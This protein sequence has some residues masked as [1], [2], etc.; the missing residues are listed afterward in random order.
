MCEHGICPSIRCVC[1]ICVYKGE[2]HAIVHTLRVLQAVISVMN[3]I[4][5]VVHSFINGIVYH[6]FQS[7]PLKVATF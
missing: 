1:I 2:K 6:T 4:I 5:T 7:S 3:K